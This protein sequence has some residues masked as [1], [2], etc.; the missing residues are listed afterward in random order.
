MTQINTSCEYCCFKEIMKTK[1]GDV[2]TGCQLGR[3]AKFKSAN[4]KVTLEKSQ[5]NSNK[6]YLIHERFCTALRQKTWASKQEDPLKA[7]REAITLQCD[8]IILVTDNNITAND[9]KLTIRSAVEQE[10]LPKSIRVVVNTD[11]IGPI[12]AYD[13][14]DAEVPDG[15]EIYVDDSRLRDEKDQRLSREK[16]ID[17]SADKANN[18]YYATFNAGCYI[19]SNFLKDIDKAINDDLK[20]ICLILPNA[21]GNGMVVQQKLHKLVMGHRE[22]IKDNDVEN[23][24]VYK[25][26]LIAKETHSEHVIV[27]VGDICQNFQS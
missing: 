21:S 1:S 27:K 5:H 14:L 10:V 13:I 26:K 9:L 12:I 3:I 7:V 2:Q 11:F 24:L 23:D 22:V 15:I 16:C 25:C 20:I 19:P 8:I 4:T 6:Y 17:I 18:T